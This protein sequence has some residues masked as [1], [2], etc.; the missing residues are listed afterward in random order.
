MEKGEVL[1]KE[2]TSKCLKNNSMILYVVC[3]S[4]HGFL[5]SCLVGKQ[6]SSLVFL[7]SSLL[8]RRRSLSLSLGLFLLNC[9]QINV[10]GGVSLV[11]SQNG[12]NSHAQLVFSD[13]TL[14]FNCGPHRVGDPGPKTTRELSAFIDGNKMFLG[15]SS[16]GGGDSFRRTSIYGES[17]DHR[18]QEIPSDTR[19][20]ASSGNGSATT[21][22]GDES[23]DDEDDEEAD[24]DADHEI[25]GIVA[26]VDDR[27]KN[28]TA[29]SSTGANNNTN[30]YSSFSDKI[31]NEKAHLSSFGSSRELVMMKDSQNMSNAVQGQQQ[32]GRMVGVG[33]YQNAVTV[34]EQDGGD[35]YYSR[36]LQ[37]TEVGSGGRGCVGGGQKNVG[38]GEIGCGLSGRK[39]GSFSSESGEN[40]RTI[41]SDPVTGTLMDDAM[42]LPC[43]HSF[44]SGGIQHIIRT[45]ACCTCSQPVSEDSLSP[46]LSLR[47]VVLAFRR[48]EEL[49][50]YRSPKRRKERCDQDKG[51]DSGPM[52]PPR[53]RGVQF[54]FAVTDRV[55]IKGNKRIPQRFVGREAIVTTQCL[56]G[57]YVVKTLDNAES[58]KLQ[59][60]SLAKVLTNPSSKAISN[61]MAPNWLETCAR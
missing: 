48:E 40:L 32:Q 49:Q 25:N 26:T 43:G 6:T 29:P 28:N 53:G 27:M 12:L 31:G 41:L 46:N 10:N 22:S 7:L 55:I 3:Q 44:G 11:S 34:L 56:N 61:E 21:P 37:G 58:V 15:F 54:P 5:E 35:V 51:G 30:K 47:A 16:Q 17:P 8:K 42:I 36:Y 20:W 2:R 33:T 9:F 50:F 13:D 1:S 18:R 57:W 39:E 14:R 59:Y 60:R 45:K 52:D 38:V 4:Q 19:N 23:E 24:L